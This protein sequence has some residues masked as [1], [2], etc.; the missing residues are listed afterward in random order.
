M[1]YILQIGILLLLTFKLQAQD[2]PAIK[3]GDKTLGITSLDI[4]VEVVGNVA[5]TTYDMLFYNPTNSILEGELA[6]PLGEGQNVS[7][8]A[9]DVNGKLR[10]AVVVEKEQGRVAFEAVVRR[11][12]DPV[13][14]EKGTGNNYKA[15]IY[16]IPAQGHKRVV[17]AH[18][19]E[20]ILSEGAHY[21]QLPLEFKKNLDHFAI[22]MVVFNQNITPS[23]SEGQLSNFEFNGLYSNFYAKTVKKNFTPKTS[24][25]IK[26]PQDYENNKT[27]VSNDYFYVYKRLN[28]E[29]RA[30][31]KSKEITLYWDVS[32]S[33]KDRDLE[34]EL[35]FLDAYFKYLK[36][37][38]VNLVTFSNAIQFETK[39]TIKNGNWEALEAVLSASI[40]DGGTSYANLFSNVTTDE[41]LLFSDGMKNLSDFPKTFTAPLFVVNSL[42]KANHSELKNS[43]ETTQG[44][45]I[46]LKNSTVADAMEAMQFQPFK[47]I[48]VKSSNKALELY[49]NK[50][51]SV[52]KDFS[53]TG[54][55]YKENDIVTLQF[56][57][58]N[59]VT[60]TETITLTKAIDN[61]LVK[62]IWA[63]KKLGV[64]QLESELNK[65]DIITHSK[66]YNLVS[67]HTS[68]IVLETV[69][70]YVRYKITPPEELLEEYNKILARNN[71]KRVQAV[72][73][74]ELEEDEVVKLN[75][76][77]KDG[78]FQGNVSGTISD[79]NG[80]PMPGV[81]VLVKGT[82][83]GT[84]TDF[85]GNYSITAAAG[86]IISFSSIGYH[87]LEADVGDSSNI[88]FGME[89]DVAAIDEVVITAL[90]IKRKRD[91]V[92]S[93][94]QEVKTEELSKANNPSVINSLSGK[95]SGLQ[96]NQTKGGVDAQSR[97]VLR[98]NRSISGNNEA[99]IVINGAISDKGFLDALGP[100]AI[101]SVNVIKG[102]SGAALYGSQGSNGVI[103]VTTKRFGN[104]NRSRRSSSSSRSRSRNTNK[105]NKYKGQL[106]IETFN[107]NA[108]YIKELS[109]T[110]T[111]EEAY[112]LY[113]KQRENYKD[114]PAYYVD[115]YDYFKTW[116]DNVYS[117]RILTNIAEI[118][119]D[120]YELLRVFAYKLEE[121]N[122]Y[123]LASY[124]YE[125]VLKL[126]TED[127]QS[128]R[129][130][131]LAYNAIGENQKAFNVLND[132]VTGNIY[133]TGE[134]RRFTGIETIAKH[135]INKV[136]QETAKLDISKFDNNN[137]IDTAFDVRIVID[138]NHN[139]TDIDLHVIDPN[140][141]ECFYSHN[142][143]KMG[144]KMS[145]D[146][147]QGFGPEEFTLKNA[148]KGTY[149][150]KVNYFGDRYQKVENPTFM[151]V[152]MYKN[153]GKPNETKEI[154]VI[155]LTK[156]K[157]KQIV[158]KIEI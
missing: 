90:G 66:L 49:P 12:V 6:F 30:R 32:L 135:E 131:A 120:N 31:K 132:I 112:A 129:D 91:A 101:E 18:E 69:W 142:E 43:C 8:L 13:L 42:V 39:Y 46:N 118:D 57:Y 106:K 16:P 139:D 83:N 40:Y 136:L 87:T 116:G 102:A 9:L 115:V 88:S 149:F 121:S 25:T 97:V 156:T 47:F 157:D 145:A 58:G 41:I 50:A 153:Y 155:R 60:K 151:K 100:N 130:L 34:K 45:Y 126:R 89:A 98:G 37:V 104:I 141:E 77:F 94:Y 119:F 1:K 56:G 80:L 117:L 20:L 138:W 108:E 53:I 33:E 63:Q 28:P 71:G 95:V 133:E 76:S 7:R 74:T 86:D 85:D 61:P 147:T 67:N 107:N 62:R 64:L 93:A 154:K 55:G 137:K 65:E 11:G 127:S 152:T 73:E 158:A 51:V 122:N 15:R 2:I 123:K 109:K 44:K 54:K 125:Q 105:S 82:N 110:E 79:E 150:V 68:L 52:G 3:V 128:Y 78:N 10:E 81:S 17:L 35:Q 111:V 134:R 27:I 146:M 23:I 99:L 4:K 103:V 48:G 148:E 144:G 59:E 38:K 84:Q 75:N 140:L 143:T 21:F 92:T 36:K 114:V 5:T 22:E 14:L 24:L 70:D 124:I 29:Q 26:I 72:Q 113:L 96:I 19:Q